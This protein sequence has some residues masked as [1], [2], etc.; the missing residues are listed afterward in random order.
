MVVS[1]WLDPK[2]DEKNISWERATYDALRPHMTPGS[3]AN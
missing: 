3:Y 1:Q 2:E